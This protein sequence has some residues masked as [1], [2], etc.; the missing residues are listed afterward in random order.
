ML[1][2]YLKASIA[3]FETD[4]WKQNETNIGIKWNKYFR[5][6]EEYLGNMYR[7]KL[8]CTDTAPLEGVT[9]PFEER[10]KKP[11]SQ[12][13]QKNLKNTYSEKYIEYR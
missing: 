8:S 2:S 9:I 13:R 1:L 10:P 6:S 11:Q 7:S 3:N 4:L 12:R 5:L